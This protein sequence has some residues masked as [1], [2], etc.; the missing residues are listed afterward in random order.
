MSLSRSE[1]QV[2]GLGGV[3]GRVERQDILETEHEEEGDDGDDGQDEDGD[4]IGLPALLGGLVD[5]A[6][7]IDPAL[8]RDEDRAEQCP[9][10]L[11]HLGDVRP[12]E[13]RGDEDRGREDDQGER[14]GGLH[15]ATDPPVAAAPRTGR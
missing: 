1:G 8:D 10:A 2:R 6:D 14:V 15:R 4:R 13:R 9:L 12:D 3:P 5:P 11:H 7:A